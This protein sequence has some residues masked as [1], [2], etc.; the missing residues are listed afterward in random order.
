MEASDHVARYVCHKPNSYVSRCVRAWADTYINV[1][2]FPEHRQG[3]HSKRLSMLSDEDV[4]EKARQW[5]RGTK[6]EKRDPFALKA[7]LEEEVL[8][9]R[10]GTVMSVGVRTVRQYMRQWAYSYRRNTKGVGGYLA[11]PWRKFL[12]YRNSAGLL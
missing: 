7:Y 9:A 1:G 5:L 11:T 2:K 8:P 12:T 6:P 3:K 10:F 4:K